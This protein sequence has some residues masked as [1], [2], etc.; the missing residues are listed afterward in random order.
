MKRLAAI[1]ILGILLF[2]SVGYQGL[3]RWLQHRADVQ[4]QARIDEGRYAPEALIEMSVAMELPYSTNWGYW[5]HFEGDVVID[6]IHY[7]YVERKLENGRMYVRCLPNTQKQT[8]LNA[9]DAFFKLAYDADHAGNSKKTT[10]IFVSNYIGDYDDASSQ[11]TLAH[12]VATLQLHMAKEPDSHQ[13][14]VIGSI[15]IPPE[16]QS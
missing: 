8:V 16:S 7:R 13:Q 11:W 4:A 5:E 15:I 12:W 9:R 14:L 2:N 6:G 1:G 3:T 10:S